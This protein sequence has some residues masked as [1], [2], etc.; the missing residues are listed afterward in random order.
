MADRGR[1]TTACKHLLESINNYF[2]KI[3]Q[4][5]HQEQIPKVG[6]QAGHRFLPSTRH[7]TQ[8][9]DPIKMLALRHKLKA[10]Q[11]SRFDM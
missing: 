9:Q 5:A 1:T 2:Y 8:R 7:K 11:A 10:L 4:K 6:D 3:K